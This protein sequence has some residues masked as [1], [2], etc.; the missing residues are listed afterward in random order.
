MNKMIPLFGEKKIDGACKREENIWFV[1]RDDNILYKYDIIN[2]TR[3]SIA[4]FNDTYKSVVFFRLHPNCIEYN[5]RIIC[6][7]DKAH[8][9]IFYNIELETFNQLEVNIDREKRLDIS[10][11]WIIDGILWCV[12]R[13]TNKIIG[14]RLSDESLF[15]EKQ[16]FKDDIDNLGSGASMSN[17]K[18]YVTAQEKKTIAVFD[19]EDHSINYIDIESNEKGYNTISVCENIV[20]LTGYKKNIYIYNMA[21]HEIEITEL[22][23]S[24]LIIFNEKGKVI[25]SGNSP[26]FKKS[27]IVGEYVVLLP[28][29]YRDTNANSIVSMNFGMKS[30]KYHKLINEIIKEKIENDIFLCMIDSFDINNIEVVIDNYGSEI[31]NLENGIITKKK[32]SIEKLNSSSIYFDNI[33]IIQEK[34]NMLFEEFVSYIQKK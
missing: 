6:I 17:G 25:K 24:E 2:K 5:N 33:D 22:D 1:S 29:F 23:D 9:F 18:I 26:I 8:S 4:T 21:T 30:I 11:F 20:Y 12:S 3:T 13:R 15:Y 10:D 16:I 31:I 32:Y 7:P 27:Y 28:W 14:V 34:K 19:V